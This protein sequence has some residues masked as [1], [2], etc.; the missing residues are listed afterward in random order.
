MLA[1]GKTQKPAIGQLNNT[2]THY[3]KEK[4]VITPKE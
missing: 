3:R 2:E 1:C 4:I